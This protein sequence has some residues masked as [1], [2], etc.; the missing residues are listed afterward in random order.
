MRPNKTDADRAGQARTEEVGRNPAE[1]VSGV[2]VDSRIPLQTKAQPRQAE[3]LE[4]VLE[5]GNLQKAYERVCCNKGAG[6]VDGIGVS[7][8]KAHLKQHWPTIRA[9]VLAGSYIPAPVRRVDIP[10]PE[11]G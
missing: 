8:F 11:G 1:S 9:K 7:E 2:E 5:P 10:M 3:L 4:A 6:G